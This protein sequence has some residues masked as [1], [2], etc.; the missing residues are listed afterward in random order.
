MHFPFTLEE[1]VFVHT[2]LVEDHFL[3]QF[4]MSY[5]TACRAT[6]LLIR[7]ESLVLLRSPCMCQGIFLKLLSLGAASVNYFVPVCE[8]YFSVS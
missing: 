7:D 6:W 5:P 1:N 8:L 4:W 2:F 3:S